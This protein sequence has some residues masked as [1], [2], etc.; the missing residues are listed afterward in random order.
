MPPRL[1]RCPARRF[2]SVA[3]CH[4]LTGGDIIEPVGRQRHPIALVAVWPGDAHFGG[5]VATQAKMPPAQLPRGMAAAA[6][7]LALFGGAAMLGIVGIVVSL[8][9]LIF[10]A[11]R[12]WNVILMAP[13]CAGVA[14]FRAAICP[15]MALCARC[16]GH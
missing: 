1:S 3:R 10:L 14:S 8:A 12:G 11:Y 9:L 7:H 2:G 13:I 16:L 6:G 15:S 5:G 4:G